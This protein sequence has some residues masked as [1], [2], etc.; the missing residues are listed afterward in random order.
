MVILPVP[1]TVAPGRTQEWTWP[2]QAQ[3][4]QEPWVALHEPWEQGLE[5]GLEVMPWLGHWPFTVQV[6][7]PANASG[8]FL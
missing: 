6:T 4:T 7:L 5:T 1:S 3:V 2:W 8:S